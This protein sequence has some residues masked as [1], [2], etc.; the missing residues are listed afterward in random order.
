M[1]NFAV[2]PTSEAAAVAEFDKFKAD[3]I[4]TIR[5][6]ML[7]AMQALGYAA[8]DHLFGDPVQ[9]RS[10]ALAG[11]LTGSARATVSGDL[12]RGTIST[13]PGGKP[14]GLWLEYGTHV[15]QVLGTLFEFQGDSGPVFARGHKAF[16]TGQGGKN[17]FLNATVQSQE[18]T[19]MQTIREHIGAAALANA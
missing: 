14:T 10:G 7:E 15:R 18:A 2:D 11:V 1:I 4:T 17:A 9:S 8:A 19:I 12:V 16:D 13:S 5:E 3:L 6:G